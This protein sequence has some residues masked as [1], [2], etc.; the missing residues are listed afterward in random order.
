MFIE[1]KTTFLLKTYLK[2]ETVNICQRYLQILATEIY[3]AKNYLGKPCD[4]RNNSTLE[5]R[6]NCSVYFC[7]DTICSCSKV[8]DLVPNDMLLEL[9]NKKTSFGQQINVLGGSVKYT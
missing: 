9:F 4:Q 7:I 8:S 2:D 6:C 1:I 5:R 3:T